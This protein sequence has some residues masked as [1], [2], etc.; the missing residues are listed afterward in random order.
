M[1][2][3]DLSAVP[4]TNRTGYP[5]PFAADVAGRFYSRLGDAFGQKDFGASH[6]ILAPGAMSAQRH[7]HEQEDEMVI[8]LSGEAVLVE[9]DSRAIMRPGDCAIFPKGVA[10]GHH[11]VNET[12]EECVFVAIGRQ[13]N[14]ICHYPDIDLRFTG[15]RDAY[16]HK[17]GAP[18]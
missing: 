5:D 15:E 7:W 13:G 1:P 6:V 3:V 18:Y 17:D 12:S 2:K 16:V 11:L 9:D 14:G 4:R 8:M 10:N